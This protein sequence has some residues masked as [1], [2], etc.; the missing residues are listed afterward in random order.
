MPLAPGVADKIRSHKFGR[1]KLATDSA[2][3]AFNRRARNEGGKFTKFLTALASNTDAQALV[4][5]I[6][7]AIR[8]MTLQFGF[9]PAN[10]QKVRL[11]MP[12][13]MFIPRSVW[14]GYFSLAT[15]SLTDTQRTAFEAAEKT[16]ADNC[17]KLRALIA[18]IQAVDSVLNDTSNA[19][20]RP[21]PGGEV[22]E[23]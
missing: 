10:D 23:P 5:A 21:N 20:D 9:T 12:D 4:T 19:T 22:G 13:E 11:A 14:Y 6:N 18:R 7:D 1:R 17:G 16:Y 3:T 8:T 2:W 15:G